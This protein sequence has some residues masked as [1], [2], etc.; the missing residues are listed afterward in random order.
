MNSKSH[1]TNVV[2]AGPKAPEALN[3]IGHENILHFFDQVIAHGNL[4]H[5]Y[6]FVGQDGVGK[7][8]MARAI[9]AKLLGV[10]EKKLNTQPDYTEIGQEVDEK[11][12]K[13]RRDI[14]I[15]QI[16]DCISFLSLSSFLGSYKIT[17]IDAAEKMNSEAANAFLK[18]L[19]EPS[20]KSILFL[21]TADDRALP[22]TIRSRCQMIY[23]PPAPTLLIQQSLE[24]RGLSLNEAEEMARLSRGLPGQALAW[25]ED[26]A[27]Y[28]EY[29]NEVIRFAS[30]W[31]KPLYDKIQTAE[32]L[33]GD[34]ENHIAGRE[35]LGNILGMWEIAVRDM[36][37]HVFGADS[38][39]VHVVETK[40]P[41]NSH[42][43]LAI[44][45]RIE[46]AR[47]LLRQNV[48][49]RLLVEEILLAIP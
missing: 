32:D 41:V 43:L 27:G 19:E 38:R 5:A 49:P 44:A 46:N 8:A 13:L 1:F 7:R 31:G 16:R 6:C 37:L 20:G 9:A 28:Q 45:H 42:S 17:V 30:L 39:R 48:H 10:E 2:H 36:F 4:S 23:F 11:T 18:T 47:R 14:I 3:M 33:F 21:L 29:K 24:E 26:R 12:G 25:L 22:R 15:K 34:K 40:D 35:R